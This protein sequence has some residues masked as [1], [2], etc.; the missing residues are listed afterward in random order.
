[1]LPSRINLSFQERD[2]DL[3]QKSECPNVAIVS[4]YVS[5]TFNILLM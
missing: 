3:L 2:V 4:L 5:I 1:M